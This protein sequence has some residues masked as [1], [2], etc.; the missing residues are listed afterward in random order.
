[1]SETAYVLIV[2]GGRSY[3]DR[4]KVFATL[5]AAGKVALLFH[6]AST[7]ADALAEDW[8]DERDV[9]SQPIPAWWQRYRRAAGPLRNV[10]MAVM[11][12]ELARLHGYRVKVIAFPGGAGTASMVG[13]AKRLKLEVVEVDP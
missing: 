10:Q 2:C 8:A 7:G 13:I 3:S 1:M 4:P 9:L 12:V 6:G 11:A 5:D